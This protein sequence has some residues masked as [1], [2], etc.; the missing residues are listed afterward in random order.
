MYHPKRGLK[1]EDTEEFFHCQNEY[2]KSL[3][4][5]ENSNK[6]FTVLGKK[7]KFSAQDSDLENLFWHPKNFQV[8]SDLKPPLVLDFREFRQIAEAKV[9]DPIKCCW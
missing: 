9:V 2:S 1:S 8:S 6:L 4:W 7:F 5:A 3:F